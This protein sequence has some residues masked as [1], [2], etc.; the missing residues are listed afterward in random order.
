MSQNILQNVCN[1]VAN[2]LQTFT[3]LLP[4]APFHFI[5]RQRKTHNNQLFQG[6]IQFIKFIVVIFHLLILGTKN[7]F[8]RFCRN[9]LLNANF[10]IRSH[11][12]W[13]DLTHGHQHF[14][15]LHIFSLETSYFHFKTLYCLFVLIFSLCESS[16]FLC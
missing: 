6:H 16:C 11:P 4:M 13:L 9:F 5:S 14:R 15:N 3:S 7:I 2:I 8:T 1:S 10:S 12:A